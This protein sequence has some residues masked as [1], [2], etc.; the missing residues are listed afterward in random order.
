[1]PFSCGCPVLILPENNQAEQI[2]VDE[3]AEWL[4]TISYEVLTGISMRVPRRYVM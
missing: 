1:M 3:I 2:S 4:G